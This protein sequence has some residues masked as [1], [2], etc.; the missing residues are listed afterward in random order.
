MARGSAA[1]QK[2]GSP[3]RDG[4]PSETDTLLS[5]MPAAS[6]QGPSIAL[7]A[8]QAPRL[9]NQLQPKRGRPHFVIK[10]MRKEHGLESCKQAC[11][12]QTWPLRDRLP[13]HS[14]LVIVL[15]TSHVHSH[16]LVLK[17]AEHM[18]VVLN[19]QTLGAGM[20]TSVSV[21]QRHLVLQGRKHSLALQNL[22]EGVASCPLSSDPRII[23]QHTLMG[24][25]N[26]LLCGQLQMS[27][28]CGCL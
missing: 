9:W 14:V 17:A 10:V 25:A 22:C 19:S 13:L 3:S 12:L 20:E 21:S 8:P 24:R 16:H 11:T 4:G 27:P 6:A 7:L 5:F 1:F 23:R 18:M 2:H 28:G 15:L 26:I